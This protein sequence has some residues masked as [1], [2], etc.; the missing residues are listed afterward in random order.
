MKRQ[1]S[2][3]PWTAQASHTWT[4]QASHTWTRRALAGLAALTACALPAGPALAASPRI[5]PD[6]GPRQTYV[7]RAA[8]SSWA[9][10]DRELAAQA[11]VVRRIHLITAD[12]VRLTSAEAA[13]WATDPRVIEVT[14]DGRVSLQSDGARPGSAVQDLDDVRAAADAVD[15]GL[16]GRGVDVA[17]V[18]SGVADVP[19]L[20]GH[21]VAGPD[22]SLE[23]GTYAQ[24]VDGFGHGTHL[25]GIIGG[26]A[27]GLL[28]V[29]PAARIVSVKVA[30]RFGNADVSQVIAGIDWVVENAHTDGRDIRI[31]NLAFGTDSR[32]DYVLDPL[33]YAAEVAWRSGIVVVVSA[34]NDGRLS[35]GLSDP[36]SDPFVLAVGASD[37]SRRG[38]PVAD[39][40]ARGDGRRNPDLVA[41]GAHLAS[42]RAPGSTIDVMF[43][44]VARTDDGL[45]RGSGTSQAAAV[46]S[47]LVAQLLQARPALTPDDVKAVLT[48]TATHVRGGDERAQGNGMVDLGA[49]LLALPDR[50]GQ[51]FTRARGGGSLEAAR[52]TTQLGTGVT[53]LVGEVDVFGR[54]VDTALLAAAERN[55][56]AWIGGS[57]GGMPL[58]DQN[59]AGQSWASQNWAGQSWASQNWAGQSWASQNWASQNWAGQS[60]AGQSWASQNW[61]GQS[62]AGQSWA[63]QNWAARNW[64]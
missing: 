48:A 27:P 13:R 60:W 33:A 3:R 23:A 15:T 14:R 17:L 52:G 30:D 5:A 32:Q 64:D 20:A 55:G 44:Q 46:M 47:G 22:L 49:A 42:L 50:S 29:A 18:D 9:V 43:G 37:T 62:W 41:P 45:F 35:A 2:A 7:V 11:P 61:A 38:N 28:G 58:V 24:D 57:Y 39:F 54:P 10:V 1:H 21:V 8:A 6:A 56:T 19:G 63:S 40:S 25:A 16:T 53:A 51:P 4:T 12:V 36:A 26:K 59:W 31:L 34:G